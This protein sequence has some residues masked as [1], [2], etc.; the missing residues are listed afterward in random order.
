MIRPSNKLDAALLASG[1]ALFPSTGCAGLSLRALAE[2]AGVN[3]GMFHYHFKSKDN[4]LRALLQQMYEEMF[5]S[6]ELEAGHDG[7]ALAR[8]RAALLALAT[9]ARDNRRLLARIWIDVLAGEPVAIAFLRDNAPRHVG[10]LVGLV[11]QARAEGVLRELP[12]VQRLA[13]VLGA[14]VMPMIF[15]AGLADT[16]IAPPAI[17]AAFDA[18]VMSDAAM[19]QRVDLALAALTAPP[20][21]PTRRPG[22]RTAA[23]R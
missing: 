20:A 7:P 21:A 11:E 13:F 3:P 19:A 14:L 2:H 10:L 17:R 8:L 23:A 9:F 6:L 1:R 4:F 18:Q 5:A 12:P 15:A 16:G 22:A